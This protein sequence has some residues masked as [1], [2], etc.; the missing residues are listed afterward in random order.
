[1]QQRCDSNMQA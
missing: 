1:M